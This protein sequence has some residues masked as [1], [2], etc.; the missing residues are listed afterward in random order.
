MTQIKRSKAI[1][2]EGHEEHEGNDQDTKDIKLNKTHIGVG[3]LAPSFIE[4]K[5]LKTTSKRSK[6]FIHRFHR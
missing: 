1:Y 4:N 3:A 6:A 2:N 5:Y